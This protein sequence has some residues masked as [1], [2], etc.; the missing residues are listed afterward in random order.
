MKNQGKRMTGWKNNKV[1]RKID[2]LIKGG[3]V[4][5]GTGDEA[6]FADIALSNE[7]IAFIS[8]LPGSNRVKAETVIKAEGLSIAPGFI[9]THGH[10]EF[11]LLADGRA[12][13]KVL[14]GITTE[15]NGNCGLS[16]GPLNGEAFEHREADLV[17]MGIKERWHTLGDY[18]LL[19][20]EK[21]IGLNFAT[22]VGHGNVRGSVIGYGES[23]PGVYEM[24]KMCM[25]VRDAIEYGA[26]GLSTG[27]IY[28]P[29]VYS[30][31]E[32]LI[33]LAGCCRDFIY[34]S[35]MRSEGDELIEAIGECVRIGRETGIPVHIS[36]LKTS[37]ERNWHKAESAISFIEEARRTG[38]R[39]TCDRY[40]YTAASTDLDS[41]LPAWTYRGG[42]DEELKRLK[43]TGLRS[44][45]TREIL[46]VHPQGDYWDKV[47]ISSVQLDKN[48][49]MEG[50][51]LSL[52]AETAG[53]R[54]VDILLDVLIEERLRTGAIFY[55]MSEQNLERFLSLPY[56]MVGSDSAARSM[57]GPARKG[58]P[59]PR[60]FGSFPRFLGRYGGE[61]KKIP[62]REAIRRIT[63]LPAETFRI[64]DRGLVREGFSADLVVFDEERITDRA[65]FDEPFQG[66]E[67]IH[68][69][70]VNGSPVVWQ[71]VPTG[72]KA[73]RVLRHGG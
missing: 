46:A 5:D 68:C 60:G 71:G 45:I 36:H 66:P 59:H 2:L 14:Q 7:R 26:I 50:K 65:T 62:L 37:G 30:E 1:T 38:I 18:L 41:I 31:T 49:W 6:Y 16:A 15:I 3:K 43:D 17:E 27:L 20:E 10:S 32:E 4:Y 8:R 70:Y 33:S 54:P 13:G 53:K 52:I 61:G 40:P 25:L 39:V 47:T 73:G 63:S 28:P 56:M 42:A 58:K 24:E 21:G 55:S 23:G 72:V 12:E 35:H 19:L 22:L 57:D 29:G 34:T 9:D 51:R 48:S 11:T 69:V 64:K 44:A 67:G